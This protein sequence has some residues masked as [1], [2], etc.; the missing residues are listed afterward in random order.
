MAAYNYGGCDSG[1]YSFVCDPNFYIGQLGYGTTIL[2][3]SNQWGNTDTTG[4]NHESAIV[5]GPP[6]AYRFWLLWGTAA[7]TKPSSQTPYQWGQTQAQQ[8]VTAWTQNN[9]VGRYTVWAD[10]EEPEYW[11]SDTGANGQVLSGFAAYMTSQL[12]APGVY[13]APAAWSD[14]MGGQTVASLGGVQIWSYEPQVGAKCP[15]SWQA[16]GFG[17]MSPNIWQFNQNPDLDVA[18]E[19]NG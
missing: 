11:V 5:V 4:W 1:T 12:A 17:G 9:Y 14:I 6:N 13:S 3:A 18:L 10:I 7:P 8:C 2:L 19:I 16:Q 15:S